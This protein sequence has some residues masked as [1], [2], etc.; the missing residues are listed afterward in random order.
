M[1]QQE[2]EKKNKRRGL[3]IAFFVHL[4]LIGLLL[5]PFMRYSIKEDVSL[6]EAVEIMVFDFSRKE[7]ASAKARSEPQKETPKETSNP[8]PAEV[9]KIE[10]LPVPEV[11]TT[12]MPEPIKLPEPSM[13]KV[14]T[15]PEPVPTPT[16]PSPTPSPN[17]TPSVQTE[18]ASEGPSGDNQQGTSTSEGNTDAVEGEGKGSRYDGLDLSG[19][20]VLTRRVIYRANLGDVVIKDGVIVI[21]I[22]VNQRG[23]VV[24]AKHNKEL[25]TITNYD[26]IRRAMDAV[27]QYRFEVD[28][29]APPRECGRLSITIRGTK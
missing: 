9:F 26:V 25:S 27:M 16:R 5:I 29:S 14:E 4:I 6:T 7:G 12:T 1:K 22:C 15:R 20:G 21:N 13:P 18:T 19:D 10:P 3:L 2:E 17:P 23:T 8:E 28:R 24:G 11:V